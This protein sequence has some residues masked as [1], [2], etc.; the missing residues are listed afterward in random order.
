MNFNLISPKN[1]SEFTATFKEPIVIKKDSKCYLNFAKFQ[2]DNAVIFTRPQKFRIDIDECIPNRCPA[3]TTKLTGGRNA[4]QNDAWETIRTINI[5]E[6]SYT[7]AGLQKSINDKVDSLFKARITTADAVFN[8]GGSNFQRYKVNTPQDDEAINLSINLP[9]PDRINLFYGD[10][11]LNAT[12]NFNCRMNTNRDANDQLQEIAYQKVSDQDGGDRTIA[13]QYDNFNISKEHFFHINYDSIGTT[14]EPKIMENSKLNCILFDV[15]DKVEDWVDPWV[16]GLNDG[17]RNMGYYVGLVS[18]EYNSVGGTGETENRTG[19]TASVCLDGGGIFNPDLD[20]NDSQA[21]LPTSYFGV[22]IYHEQPFEDD[23]EDPYLNVWWGDRGDENTAATM[24]TNGAGQF[25][26]VMNMVKRVPLDNHYDPDESP[27]CRFY[28]YNAYNPNGDPTKNDETGVI[29]Y[30]KT[31]VKVDLWEYRNANWVTVYDSGA[32][33]VSQRLKQYF[34]DNFFNGYEKTLG[35]GQSAPQVN[36]SIPFSVICSHQD[37]DGYFPMIKQTSFN[38][39]PEVNTGDTNPLTIIKKW[40]FK[41]LTQELSDLLDEDNNVTPSYQ[42]SVLFPNVIVDNNEDLSGLNFKNQWLYN[43]NSDV[44]PYWARWEISNPIR[45]QLNKINYSI[46]IDNLP[47]SNYKNYEKTSSQG[48]KKN[49]L[50]NIPLPFLS[51]NKKTGSLLS[52]YQPSFQILNKMEN[53][54]IKTNNLKVSVRSMETD[55]PIRHLENS[56]INFTIID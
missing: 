45:Q 50:G 32:T 48:Y 22:S 11:I 43:P 2:R 5:P 56:V 19:G 40:S 12:S 6:G 55:E 28:T 13:R 49:I 53:Q 23:N 47:L 7:M 15:A 37:S 35:V 1:K 14:Y 39:T 20:D 44:R 34:G 8:F 27:K 24:T 26:S 36:A 9:K 41:S 10:V 4:T 29:N 25:P 17:T 51:G 52:L 54:E 30:D 33:G 3:D 31:F 16:G 38:K 18:A 21:G 42:S 46:Y